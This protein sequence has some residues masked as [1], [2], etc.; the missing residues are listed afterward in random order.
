MWP[1]NVHSLG[2]AFK[3]IGGAG[4]G[5]R[6]EKRNVEKRIAAGQKDMVAMGL[7]GYLEERR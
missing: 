1:V 4:E 3:D 7:D 2:R 6:T 5:R